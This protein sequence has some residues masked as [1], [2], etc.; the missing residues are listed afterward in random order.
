MKF[1]KS[2]FFLIAI[3]ASAQTD[4]GIGVVSVKFD[5][6]TVLS[7]YSKTSDAKPKQ[8]LEFFNDESIKSINIKNLEKQQKWLAPEVLWIDYNYFVFR[9]KSQTN[10]AFEVIV[11]NE[12]GTTLWLKKSKSTVFKTWENYMKGMFMIKRV[13]TSIA[14]DIRRKAD[15]NAEEN[16]F[17]GEECFQVKSMKGDWIE[18]STG[19]SCEEDGSILDSGWIKWRDKNKLLIEYFLTS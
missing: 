10:D 13:E 11:N 18:I 1:L 16:I 7:F 8:I 5:E 2:V 3:N 6:K 9:C 15:D 17:T 19:E 14:N 4:L 12:T